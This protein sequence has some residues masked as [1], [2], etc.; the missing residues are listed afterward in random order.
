MA[1]WLVVA[2]GAHYARGKVKA[3]VNVGSGEVI[4]FIV[5]ARAEGGDLSRRGGGGGV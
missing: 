3:A 5:V 2:G 4:S 1:Q